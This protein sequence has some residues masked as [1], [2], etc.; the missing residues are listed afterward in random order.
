MSKKPSKSTAKKKF[1]NKHER[2]IIYLHNGKIAD[3]KT[4]QILTNE[5]HTS[6]NNHLADIINFKK[7]EFNGDVI[8]RNLK[9]KF[10]YTVHYSKDSF[11]YSNLTTKSNSKKSTI[12]TS[13]TIKTNNI[14]CIDW[15]LIT[16]ITYTDGSQSVS[17][18]YVG[19][20][21]H[22]TCQSDPYQ[23]Q[24]FCDDN[25]GGGGGGEIPTEFTTTPNLKL[26]G[27]YSWTLSGGLPDGAKNTVIGNLTATF[28][29]NN[30]PTITLSARFADACVTIPN[31]CSTNEYTLSLMFNTAFNK[32]VS[33]VESRLGS[34]GP[35][36]IPA[37]DYFV[38][39]ELKK[40]IQKELNIECQGS[41]FNNGGCSSNITRIKPQFCPN[42]NS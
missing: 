20:T 41:V 32:A 28:S 18:E 40:E 35:G 13:S 36:Q 21:C 37:G 6:I 33:S 9:G 39:E 7:S 4:V 27:Q 2:L 17:E 12:K 15:Y 26:C 8:Y 19:T 22:S 1:A 3:V 30:N 23:S 34:N 11:G 24:N 5:D 42:P 10:L 38:Y 14:E 29:P 31:Y 16:T 25:P